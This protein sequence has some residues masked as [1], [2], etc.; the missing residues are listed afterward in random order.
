MPELNS[1]GNVKPSASGAS[2]SAGEV[3]DNAALVAIPLSAVKAGSQLRWSM[4]F[5]L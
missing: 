4:T 2:L 3:R 1:L 5:F